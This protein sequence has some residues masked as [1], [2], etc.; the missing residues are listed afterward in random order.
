[1]S[2]TKGPW[3]VVEERGAR[4]Q[5]FINGFQSGSIAKMYNR[6][7][8][9]TDAR[10]IAA[11]PDLLADHEMNLVELDFLLQAILAGDPKEQLILRVTDLIKRT[12]SSIQKAEVTK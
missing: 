1:M 9:Q 10:L 8:W 7:N 12:K 4:P 11:A 2:H 3:K 5:I 6:M